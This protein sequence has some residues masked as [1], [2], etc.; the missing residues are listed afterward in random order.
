M[1]FM[2]LWTDDWIAGTHPLTP[3]EKGVLITLVCHFTN[4]DRVIQDHDIYNARLCNMTTR[5][6]KRVKKTLVEGDYL[7]V[8]EGHIW[9]EKSSAQFTKDQSYSKK[10][11]EKAKLKHRYDKGKALETKD[12]CSAPAVPSL[13]LPLLSSSKE[14]VK[15]AKADY[16]FEGGVIKLSKKNLEEWE[17]V[18]WAIPDIKAELYSLDSF[19]KKSLSPADKKNWFM[20]TSNHLKNMHQ[21]NVT[22]KSEGT[23]R[24]RNPK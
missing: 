3:E 1:K 20:R 22:K 12:S 6:F 18:F 17:G 5:A 8:R 14:E 11:A 9:I 16:A 4:K 23:T 24:K 10:Q 7:E 19:Y 15:A 13:P 21:K 2:T